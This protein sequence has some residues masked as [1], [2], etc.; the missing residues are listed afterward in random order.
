[1]A[2][3]EKYLRQTSNGKP[4]HAGTITTTGGGLG[5]TTKTHRV[6]GL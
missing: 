3:G 1:M 6:V 5:L 4:R 2:P